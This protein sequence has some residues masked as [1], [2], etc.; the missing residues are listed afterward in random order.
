M[1]IRYFSN[2]SVKYLQVIKVNTLTPFTIHYF[3]LLLT[4]FLSFCFCY[5]ILKFIMKVMFFSV[6]IY[7][8]F[9]ACV[10]FKDIFIIIRRYFSYIFSIFVVYLLYH[11]GLIRL[12]GDTELNPGPKPSSFK[13][14]SIC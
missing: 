6:L 8:F 12:S 10:L 7:T 4:S 3:K 1:K 13:Y 2:F 14:S 9:E 11:I 5:T